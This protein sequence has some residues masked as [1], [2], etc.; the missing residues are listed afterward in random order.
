MQTDWKPC[1]VQLD[2]TVAAAPPGVGSVA[3]QGVGVGMHSR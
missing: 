3:L 2:T 1:G